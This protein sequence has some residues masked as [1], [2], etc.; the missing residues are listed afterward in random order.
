MY[1]VLHIFHVKNLGPK[2][3]RLISRGDI[4][5]RVKHPNRIFEKD[6]R[7]HMPKATREFCVVDFYGNFPTGRGVIRYILVCSDVFTKFVKL[8]AVRAAAERTCCRKLSSTMK[9][10]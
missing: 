1:Q 7:S 3:Q 8:Y 6:S 4:F 5:Q 10:T 2:V 9:Q